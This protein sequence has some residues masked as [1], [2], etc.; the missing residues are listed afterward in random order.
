MSAPPMPPAE[1]AK[2][3]DALR[4]AL[5][6]AKPYQL[7]IT[8]AERTSMAPKAMGR[9]SI[10]FAQEARALLTNHPEVLRRT[11]TDA[12]IADYPVQLEVFEQS[13]E[14]AEMLATIGD[15]VKTR[16]LVS[17]VRVMTTGRD[18]Y[19]DGQNDRG[20]TPG[21][22]PII[23]RMSLRFNRSAEDDDSDTPKS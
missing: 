22:K 20:R 11:I 14:A 2:F 18:S 6:I 16:R 23:D 9:E 17:G 1:H 12:V 8:D 3:M 13:D 10:P 4:Q 7:D 5:S 19:K 21:V 15:I